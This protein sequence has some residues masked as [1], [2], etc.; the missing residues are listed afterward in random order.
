MGLKQRLQRRMRLELL[1]LDGKFL[2]RRRRVPAAAAERYAF[3]RVL[4]AL[5]WN[6]HAFSGLG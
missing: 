6:R 5:H 4:L 2:P 3:L 1:H